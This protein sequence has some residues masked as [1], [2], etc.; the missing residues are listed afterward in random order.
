MIK[1]LS[2]KQMMPIPTF[3]LHQVWTRILQIGSISGLISLVFT[4]SAHVRTRRRFSFGFQG[5]SGSAATRGD[6]E[7]Y[8]WKYLGH[9]KNE[10][11]EPN[12][13]VQVGYVVWANKARTRTLSN[14]MNAVIKDRHT[15]VELHAP[16][17]FSPLEGKSLQIEFAVCL[18]G[19]HDRE[20]IL[21]RRQILGASRSLSLPKHE[22]QLVFTDTNGRLFDQTGQLRSQKLM[23]LWWTLENTR[24]SLKRGNPLPYLWH[25]T[26]IV[27]TSLLFRIRR[28]FW[29]LGL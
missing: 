13:I 1:A 29:R 24:R 14:G 22:Y 28:F 12:S 2:S 16:I 7:F 5:S 21:A 23:N 9:V 11:S 10:S 17:S 3:N 26:K 15:G 19:T 20:I 27:F 6:L 8:D 4:I 18:T 25:M